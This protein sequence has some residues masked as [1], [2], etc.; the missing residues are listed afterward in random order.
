NLPVVVRLEGEL[1]KEKFEEV[2][3]QL[4]ARHES[5]RTSFEM[6]EEEPVQRIHREN[7]KFQV[8]N[9]KPIPSSQFQITNIIRNFVQSFDLSKAPLLRVG[10]IESGKEQHILML[11]MHH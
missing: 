2:F 11:D 1:N 4:T 6:K 9:Y 7:Y 5:F 3:M 8:T 10:L